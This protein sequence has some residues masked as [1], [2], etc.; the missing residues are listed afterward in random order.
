MKQLLQ[1]FDLGEIM[2]LFSKHF[3]MRGDMSVLKK[4]T[5]GLGVLLLIVASV[6]CV[7]AQN[8]IK[9]PKP[10][11]TGKVSLETAILKKKSVRGFSNSPLNLEE[12]SQLLWAA[13]GNLPADAI[14]GATSKVLPSAGG[15]Y[16]LEVFAVTGADTVSGLPAGVYQYK[17]ETNSLLSINPGDNRS[18]LA[19]AALGQMWIASAPVIIVIGANFNRTTVKYGNRGLQYVF[20]ESGAS[21]QNIYLQSESLGLKV[22]SVGAFQDSYVTGALK[23]PAD[24]N[25]LMLIPVGK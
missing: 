12:V 5:A 20:M 7:K 21:T 24:V 14:S 2:G 19:R 17:P 6:E 3:E 11:F 23:L 25:P 8:E 15:L 1:W 9:L 10:K 22:G 18:L 16:P 4:M 13:N